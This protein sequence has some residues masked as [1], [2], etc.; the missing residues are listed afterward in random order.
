MI[1]FLE[2]VCSVWAEIVGLLGELISH[3]SC[4]WSDPRIMMVLQGFPVFMQQLFKTV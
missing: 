3:V 1:V 4:E 2:A